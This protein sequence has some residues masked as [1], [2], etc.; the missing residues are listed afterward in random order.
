M[1]STTSRIARSTTSAWP[2]PW[3]WDVAFFR[4]WHQGVGSCTFLLRFGSRVKVNRHRLQTTVETSGSSQDVGHPRMSQKRNHFR[5]Y[6]GTP[7]RLRLPKVWSQRRIR[8]LLRVPRIMPTLP[9]S[10]SN[11]R[12]L[13]TCTMQPSRQ[14]TEHANAVTFSGSV[15]GRRKIRYGHGTW[16]LMELPLESIFE[17]TNLFAKRNRGKC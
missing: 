3:L 14:T 1:W 7:V 6:D 9:S 15:S 8:K 5:V 2:C 12:S 4:R 16:M 10:Q 11:Q 13:F 17:V